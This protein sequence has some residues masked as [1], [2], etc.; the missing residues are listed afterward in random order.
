MIKRILIKF[1]LTDIVLW[2]LPRKEHHQQMRETI[3]QLVLRAVPQAATCSWHCLVSLIC[4]ES[5][6]AEKLLWFVAPVIVGFLKQD[7]VMH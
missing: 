6:T 4:L 7:F 5:C 2:F 3:L 1:H